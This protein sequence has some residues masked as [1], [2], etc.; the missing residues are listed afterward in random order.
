M[1]GKYITF[2]FAWT[3]LSEENHR[4]NLSHADPR[5]TFT[6]YEQLRAMS[7]AAKRLALTTKQI[8]MLFA[9]TAEALLQST[10]EANRRARS[11]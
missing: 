10:R 4:F 6:R 1:R 7:R 11:K 3:Y 8:D 5:M 9:G 2:G